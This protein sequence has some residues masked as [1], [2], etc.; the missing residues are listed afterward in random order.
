MRNATAPL[1]CLSAALAAGPFAHGAQQGIGDAK[2]RG[3]LIRFLPAV[4]SW[5]EFFDETIGLRDEAWLIELMGRHGLSPSGAGGKGGEAGEVGVWARRREDDPS[6]AAPALVLR[7]E[8]TETLR[9]EEIAIGAGKDGGGA[10]K[11]LAGR[12]AELGLL[13]RAKDRTVEVSRFFAVLPVPGGAATAPRRFDPTIS[14]P[15]GAEGDAAATADTASRKPSGDTPPRVAFNFSV[16]MGGSAAYVITDGPAGGGEAVLSGGRHRLLFADADGQ[17]APFTAAVSSP[18]GRPYFDAETPDA[19][20]G[21]QRFCIVQIP[22]RRGARG[23]AP[24][25]FGAPPAPKDG[26]PPRRTHSPEALPAPAERHIQEGQEQ[27]GVFVM[28]QAPPM[29]LH[30]GAAEEPAVIRR[31][32]V[33]RVAV[34]HGAPEGPYS[35]G[36]GFRGARDTGRPIR[37]AFVY[38]MAP[39]ANIRESDTKALVEAIERLGGGELL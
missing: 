4:A 6:S 11:T 30:L 5:D 27:V 34:G 26:R 25:D 14:Y 20:V 17:R 1:I 29:A 8:K 21:A 3:R 36:G 13:H 18:A 38:L 33:E 37:V 35:P 2:A 32:G 15:H 28:P 39:N 10:E 19:A 16:D 22:L 12:L 24:S 7:W 23:L 9:P 31:P